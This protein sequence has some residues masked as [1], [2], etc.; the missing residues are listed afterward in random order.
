MCHTSNTS[1]TSKQPATLTHKAQ[2]TLKRFSA[3]LVICAGSLG[4][5]M[6]MAQAAGSSPF[7]T[8][9]VVGSAAGSNFVDQMTWAVVV[10]CKV[11]LIAIM[12]FGIVGGIAFLWGALQD[13]R[14]GDGW[15]GFF[16]SLAIVIACVVGASVLASVAWDWIAAF[17][18][19]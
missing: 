17:K 13:A 9:K 8:G 7:D 19:D 14:R 4:H 2:Q 12:L 3:S 5:Q 15:S 18:I 16:V 1:H 11:A 10:I 6:A